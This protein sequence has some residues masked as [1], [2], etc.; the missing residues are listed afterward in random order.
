MCVLK[1]TPPSLWIQLSAGE[2]D[3]R[4]TSFNHWWCERPQLPTANYSSFPLCYEHDKV[5]ASSLVPLSTSGVYHTYQLSYPSHVPLR[6]F[7]FRHR[8]PAASFSKLSLPPPPRK[9]IHILPLRCLIHALVDAKF[10]NA[11]SSSFICQIPIAPLYTSLSCKPRIA[12]A[13]DS[14]TS[15]CDVRWIPNKYLHQTCPCTYEYAVC[16]IPIIKSSKHLAFTA[17]ATWWAVNIAN[18]SYLKEKSYHHHHANNKP[19]CPRQNRHTAPRHIA[20]NRIDSRCTH[21]REC[22]RYLYK[23]APNFL[24]S[25]APSV[26][27]FVFT[28]IMSS[29]NSV[30]TRIETPPTP[31]AQ[32][33]VPS[34]IHQVQYRISHRLERC[35]PPGIVNTTAAPH[36]L[37]PVPRSY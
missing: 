19:V 2:K 7:L 26:S 17:I 20:G 10:V 36:K 28:K 4:W 9:I 13:S 30:S 5:A 18:R 6:L 15:P 27:G 35:S 23:S 12:T 8:L 29:T 1:S 33:T 25:A 34:T 22:A 37:H 11:K 21:S 16:P 3:T 14:Y 24:S 31:F 32:S